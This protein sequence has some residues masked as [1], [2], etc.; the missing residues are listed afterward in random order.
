MGAV[1]NYGLDMVGLR[2]YLEESLKETGALVSCDIH[3]TLI[4]AGDPEALVHAYCRVNKEITNWNGGPLPAGWSRRDLTDFMKR[5]VDEAPDRC[6]DCAN[7]A[8]D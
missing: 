6:P 8:K 5:V 4:D 1:K 2:G 3:E 7:S